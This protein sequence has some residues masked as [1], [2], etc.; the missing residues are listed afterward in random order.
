MIEHA[1]RES[2]SARLLTQRRDET[3]RFCNR[4]MRFDL[5]QWSS[6]SRVLLE[7]ASTTHV[8][9]PIHTAHRFLR[10]CDFHQEH[11]LLER[12]LCCEFR[13]KTT[14]PGGWHDLPR[15]SVNRIGV[16]RHVHDVETDSAH[17]LL[18]QRPLLS[19]PLEGTV[20][21][22]LDLD[23]ILHTLRRID[24]DICTL[25][26]WAITPIFRAA[27]SSQSN[28]SFIILARSLGSVFAPHFP[29]SISALTS[30][31]NGSATR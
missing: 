15:P 9:T 30:S 12:G 11:W 2:L 27:F 21:M 8:H 18:T 20:N 5:H 26:F 22:L 7:N 1:L 31:G 23:E 25:C 29:D 16:E 24:N 13:R 19:R 17:V 14:S 4:Q 3:E 10:T 6:L 28:F